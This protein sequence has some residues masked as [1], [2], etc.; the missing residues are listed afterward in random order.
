M[1]VGEV[2]TREVY[3]VRRNEP[4]L[5]AVREM[6]A[7]NVGCVI[8][9]EPRGARTLPI[10]V[11]TDRDVTRALPERSDSLPSL[12]VEDCMTPD[13]LTLAEDT[14]IVDA[15]ARL[16]AR[17]VRRAPVVAADGDLV[18]VVSTDDLLGIVAEQLSDL[19]RLVERQ[20]RRSGPRA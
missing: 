16:R 3:I 5:E 13:P 12:H 20:G 11:L 14:S 2:C 4:L 6:R 19:A 15:M 18:G 9:V 8:V 17:G 1:N 10:G 7:R